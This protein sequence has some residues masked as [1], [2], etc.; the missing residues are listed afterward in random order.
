MIAHA[1]PAR[2]ENLRNV[3][4]EAGWNVHNIILAVD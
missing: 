1:F 4:S 2:A 3:N